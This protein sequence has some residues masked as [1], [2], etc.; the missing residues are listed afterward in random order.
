MSQK[1]PVYG[2][3]W[4]EKSRL[5]RFNERFTKKYNENSDIRYFLEVDI[6]YPKNVFNLHKDFPFL[7]ER[8]KVNKCGKRIC[9]KEDKEKYVVHIRALK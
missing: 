6:D 7:S 3:K 4:G 2:F 9:S 1:L 5:L 8:K